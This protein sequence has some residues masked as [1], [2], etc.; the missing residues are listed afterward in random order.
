MKS[1]TEILGDSQMLLDISYDIQEVSDI[2]LDIQ[3]PYQPG[4]S[5][6]TRKNRSKRRKNPKE[7]VDALRKEK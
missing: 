6:L 1:V 5:L 2:F 4:K 7:S 3:Q